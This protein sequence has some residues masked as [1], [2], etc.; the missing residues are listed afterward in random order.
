MSSTEQKQPKLP[1]FHRTLSPEENALIG[2]I[3][4]KP[5]SSTT[6]SETSG[7]I[8]DGSAWNSAKTWEER[9]CSSWARG[10]LKATL[11]EKATELQS[12][13][14]LLQF[15]SFTDVSGDAQITHIRGTARFM[16]EM[17]FSCSFSLHDTA[18]KKKHEGKL[19]VADVI[20]DQL[21]DME[22]TVDSWTTGQTPA[23][24]DLKAIKTFLTGKTM[25]KYLKDA[26]E[27]FNQKYKDI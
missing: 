19:S 23:N 3:T 12:G 1:Y 22:I 26:I 15:K 9:D 10:V 24:A 17:S 5:L 7:K 4:P 18:S 20:N 14:Y 2:D 27:L 16:Y 8:S 6:S 21:D 11:I 25:K 13:I